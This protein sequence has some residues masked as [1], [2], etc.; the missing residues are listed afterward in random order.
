VLATTLSLLAVFLPVAFMQSIPGRFLR[1]FGLTMGAAIA[2]SLLVSFTLTPMLSSR[3]L[4]LN[5][6]GTH[7]K[8]FLERLSDAFY[9]PIERVYMGMLGFLFRE[10][11]GCAKRASG[12][13]ASSR[14]SWIAAGWSGS[15]RWSP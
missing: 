4:K 12:G 11:A 7:R 2:I 13:R 8:N 3:L 1:S 6:D 10:A 14:S 15:P 5:P 9:K